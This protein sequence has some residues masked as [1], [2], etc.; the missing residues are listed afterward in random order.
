MVESSWSG[1]QLNLTFEDKNIGRSALEGWITLDVA[2]QAFISM[3]TSYNE[4]KQQALSKDFMPVEMS[5]RRFQLILI[6]L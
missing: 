6:I 4:M 1:E 3:G 5:G 2:E